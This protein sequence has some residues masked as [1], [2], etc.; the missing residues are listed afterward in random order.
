MAPRRWRRHVPDCVELDH[1]RHRA[2]RRLQRRRPDRPGGGRCRGRL[3]AA[4]D[5]RRQLRA[6]RPGRGDRPRESLDRGRQRRR[7]GGRPGGRGERATSSIGGG[8]RRLPGTFDPPIIVNPGFPSRD[9][10]WVPDSRGWPAPR[11]R[12]RPERRRHPLRR[13]GMAT[14]SC[15]ASLATGPLP[16][17]VIAA[18]LN[19]DG[20]DDLVVRNAGDGSLSVYFNGGPGA[21]WP[22]FSPFVARGDRPGRSGPVRRRGRGYPRRGV[23]PD[24]VVT[25]ELTGQVSVL[26]NDGAGRFASARALSRRGRTF[27]GRSPAPDAAGHERGRRRPGSAAGPLTTG[28]PP[29]PGD[30]QPR[31]SHARRARGSGWR[32]LRQSRRDPH[33]RARPGPSRMADFNGDGI[34]DLA[35]LDPTGRQHL[36][37]RTA[38]AAS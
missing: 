23:V 9:I 10:A 18:D 17:Q 25:D 19:G 6:R 33:R 28:G 27:G 21:S 34:P 20:R 3:P 11:Q 5:R 30:D 35:V 32:P 12:G 37:G 16:A 7:Y 26:H 22:G 24:L 8:G 38:G 31:Y 15:I 2:A 36:P 14:S 4:G 13:S 1:Q 29:A